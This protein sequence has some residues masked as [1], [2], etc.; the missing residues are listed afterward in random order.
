MKRTLLFIL[1]IMLAAGAIWAQNP[2]DEAYIKAMTVQDNCEKV[3]LLKEFINQYAGK[4]SQYENYAY[5]YLCLLPCPSKSLQESLN[6]GEKA[7]SVGGLDAE[8]KSSLIIFLAN[9]Y[10]NQGQNLDKARNYANQLIE[11]GKTE[12]TKEGANP[13]KW[14]KII[15][16]GHYILGNAAE[17]AKDTATAVE[18]YL[19]AYALSKDKGIMVSLRKMGKSY[20]EAKN[21][22]E[23]EKVYRAIYNQTKDPNDALVLGQ[24]LNRAG[25]N[26]EALGL[27]KEAYNKKKTG[28]VAFSIAVILANKA[29][30]DPTAVNE[31]VRYSLEAAFLPNPNSEQAMKMA[32]GLFFTM[33]KDLKYNETVLAIQS[34]VKELEEL[35]K[36]FNERFGGKSEEELTDKDK[37]KMQEFQADIDAIQAEIDKLKKQQES[38]IAKFNQLVEETKRRLGK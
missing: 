8:V 4:G 7:L 17:K 18:A 36:I 1:L 15:A 6:Y 11:L 25:K 22:A 35:T 32:E 20:A 24:L 29:K 23:A 21:Y 33:N 10:V 2:G 19:N 28:E 16:A 34:K 30:T 14:N 9:N 5:A 31:A 37:K 12:K 3:K 26:E 38:A 27:L 13:D